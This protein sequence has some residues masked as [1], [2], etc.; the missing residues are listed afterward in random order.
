VTARH[1]EPQEITRTLDSENGRSAT[2][3][4]RRVDKAPNGNYRQVCDC[5]RLAA[6]YALA[7][8]PASS[9]DAN[10]SGAA[11]AAQRSSTPPISAPAS[12]ARIETNRRTR[13]GWGVVSATRPVTVKVSTVVV[14]S[15]TASR[16]TTAFWPP[17]ATGSNPIT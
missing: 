11:S 6:T 10:Q 13:T 9:T 4:R 1:Q 8:H 3:D 12:I 16:R 2:I 17:I 15:G 7:A 5:G 14:R